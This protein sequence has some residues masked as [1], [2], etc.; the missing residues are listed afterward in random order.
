MLISFKKRVLSVALMSI[1]LCGCQGKKENMSAEDYFKSAQNAYVH[2]NYT[3]ALRDYEQAGKMGIALAYDMLGV[4]YRDG[5]GVSKDDVR[6]MQYFKKAEEMGCIA[7]FKNLGLMY[8]EGRGVAKSNEKAL[9]Y[10]K[11]ADNLGDANSAYNLGVMY[12]NGEG[13]DKNTQEAQSYFKKACN[14][15]LNQGCESLK[16]LSKSPQNH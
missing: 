2:K 15:G 1:I 12:E 3:E 5:E 14:R 7:V 9:E 11:K 8:Y 4:M 16:K 13:V 10:F 6:A